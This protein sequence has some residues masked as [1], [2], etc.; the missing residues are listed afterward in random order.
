MSI[1]LSISL[2]F[3]FLLGSQISIAQNSDDLFSQARTAAFDHK[4]YTLAKQLAKAAILKS[5]DYLEIRIFLGRIYTWE[6]QADSARL[7]FDKIIKLNPQVEDVYIAYSNLEFWNDDTEKA[8]TICN[9][10]MSLFQN[11]VD[12]AILKAKFLNDLKKWSEADQVISEVLT[13]HPNQTEARALATRIRENSATNRI[14]VNY[15]FVSFD[16]QFADPWH[17]TSLDYSRQTSFG[18]IIGRI[19][20]A[21][22]FNGNGVQYEVDAYPR[23]SNTFMAYISG[24][25]SPNL[26]VF[27]QTRAGFSLYA[28]LPKSM[29]AEA[30]FRYLQFGDNTWIYTASLGKYVK[31]FWFNLRTYLTP[32]SGQVGQSFTLTTRYYVGG[33]D[34]FLSLGLS[35]GLSPDDQRNIVLINASSYKLQSNGLT[36]AYRRSIN[37]F[38]I[39]NFKASWTNQEYQRDTRGNSIELGVGYIRRF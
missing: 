29:E 14:G 16:K 9:Q 10:G 1:K 6:K 19:N 33:T 2:F 37:S 27:P 32:S 21:N 24:G 22:R 39:I 30:G 31:S 20:Y 28:N 36:L 35:T 8:L 23:L 34:D 25:Y 3:I 26:G 5:P 4:Q 7:E 13:K 18:S 11:S 12:L 17:L 38:H 15:T